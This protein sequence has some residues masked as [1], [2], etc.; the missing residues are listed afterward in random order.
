[1][2]T[3][4][5]TIEGLFSSRCTEARSSHRLL[6]AL[7]RGLGAGGWD[8]S[9]RQGL[10]NGCDNKVSNNESTK[11]AMCAYC[12]IIRAIKDGFLLSLSGFVVQSSLEALF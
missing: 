5:D 10:Y 6:L 3:N 11:V 1:M 4:S 7:R 9:P 2:K 12:A 8:R